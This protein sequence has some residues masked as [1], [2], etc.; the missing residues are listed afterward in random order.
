MEL[1]SIVRR[2]RKS[3]QHAYENAYLELYN[4]MADRGD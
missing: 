1:G 2:F 3:F 4:D